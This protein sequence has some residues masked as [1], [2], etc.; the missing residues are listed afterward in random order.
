MCFIAVEVNQV[1]AAF[2]GEGLPEVW[3]GS[4]WDSNEH[5]IEFFDTGW[6]PLPAKEIRHYISST[7]TNI[8]THDHDHKTSKTDDN[9]GEGGEL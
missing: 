7:G 9:Q 5:G 4:W 1:R 8:D 3:K 2:M 6:T